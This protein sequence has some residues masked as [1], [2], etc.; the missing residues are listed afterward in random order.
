MGI[1]TT[2]SVWAFPRSE[3][4]RGVNAFTIVFLMICWPTLGDIASCREAATKQAFGEITKECSFLATDGNPEAQYYF[5]LM[6]TRGDGV[7][8]DYKEAV[9]WYR[10]AADRGNASAQFNLGVMYDHGDG[11]PQDY[12]LAHMW[13]NLASANGLEAGRKARDEMAAMMTPTQIA[14]AQRRAQEWKPQ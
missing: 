13:F 2:L 9:R 4:T 6:Y 14:E 12:I 1:D 10:L 5:G 3:Y 11:F 7:A 8:Q